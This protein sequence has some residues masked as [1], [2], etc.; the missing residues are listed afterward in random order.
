MLSN[1]DYY[2]ELLE[3]HRLLL[4]IF[5]NNRLFNIFSMM[6][7]VD[8]LSSILFHYEDKAIALA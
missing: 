7:V 2:A 3:H 5:S 6:V 1:S 8:M 4:T